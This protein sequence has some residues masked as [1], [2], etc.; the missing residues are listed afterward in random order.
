MGRLKT[1]EDRRKTFLRARMRT[2][3]GWCDV[4]IGN[5][6][7]RGLLL[8]CIAPMERNSFIEV[9]HRHVCIVGRIV[10]VGGSHCG[11][12]T[13]DIIEIEELLSQAPPQRRRAGTERRF[14]PRS[15]APPPRA[16]AEAVAD[17]SRRIARLF[18]WSVMALAAG[19]AALFVA[20]SAWGALGA[21]LA[22]VGTAL[23]GNG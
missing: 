12:R 8:H 6:S 7:S 21:P 13:Q 16:T 20:Q 3:R 11:V 1:R 10:W 5:V 9:R 15:I 19:G 22:R 23:A 14:T 4:T 18:D 2:D 17:D